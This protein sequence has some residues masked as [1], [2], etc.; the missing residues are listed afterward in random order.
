MQRGK[1][2]MAI[3]VDEYGGTAGLVTMEDLLEEIVGEIRDEHDEGEEEPIRI[4]DDDE[5]VVDAGMN[6]E[7]VNA[8]LGTQLAARR[9]RDDRRLRPSGCSGGCRTKAKRSTPTRHIRLNVERTRGRRILSLRITKPAISANGRA[10]EQAVEPA[11]NA[12]GT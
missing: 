3:V 9:V 7:D 4:V 10:G 12:E 5:A 11:S 1:F 6:I 8:K 2:S